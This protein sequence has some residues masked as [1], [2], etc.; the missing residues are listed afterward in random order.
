VRRY[1]LKITD[2]D[3]DHLRYLLRVDPKI[4]TAVFLLAGLHEEQN[5]TTILVRRIIEIPA[6]EYDVRTARR[7]ELST[8]A[9]NGLASLCESNNLIAVLVHS[10]VGASYYSP[11]DDEGESRIHGTLRSFTPLPLTASLLVTPDGVHGRVWTDGRPASMSELIIV[12]RTIRR[13]KLNNETS[14]SNEADA[15]THSRQVLA[16]GTVGQQAL[17][18]LKI[19]IVGT[20]G[21][22][23]PLA[24]QL[25][26]LGVKDLVLVD[27]DH[28]DRSSISRVYGSVPADLKRSWWQRLR[29]RKAKVEVVGRYLTR[30]NPEASILAVYGDVTDPVI[31]E[32]LLDRD[33]L[34]ACTD[35]HWGRSVLNSLA[36]Q[37]LIPTFNLGMAI[38]STDGTITAGV[39]TVQLLR[40][41]HGCLW[42]CGFLNSDVISAE[43]MMPAEREELHKEGYVPELGNPE[44]SVVTLT[45][46]VAGMAGTWFLQL[47][48]DFMG[49]AGDFSRLNYDLMT[50][51]VGRGRI[52]QHAKCVCG[53]EKGRGILGSQVA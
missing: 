28:L 20:G 29:P 36:Y 42:C 17:A 33:V 7:I 10:H 18:G 2:S 40:P 44:P 50:G 5:Q 8:R 45:T 16:F 1:R 31:A 43:S 49:E 26:R 51:T 23:S 46:T 15:T 6:T 3:Y 27:R 48:T 32:K 38:V 19:G 41:G 25:V 47:A 53:R 34:F 35:E 11:S 9:V 12:G 22:G 37:Y 24:E 13:V 4:E 14:E 52:P 21:T 30:I 39:G